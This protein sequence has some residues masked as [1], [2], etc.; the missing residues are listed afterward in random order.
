MAKI[1]IKPL[2]RMFR[3]ADALARTIRNDD[4]ASIARNRA[5]NTV[6]ESA[7]RKEIAQILRQNNKATLADVQ[8]S[9]SAKV[10]DKLPPYAPKEI[11]ILDD[12]LDRI[13]EEKLLPSA[14]INIL[15]QLKRKKPTKTDVQGVLSI[16]NDDDVIRP[17][18]QGLYL[19]G[20]GLRGEVRYFPS[21]SRYGMS[22]KTTVVRDYEIGEKNR[23]GKDKISPVKWDEM[24]VKS[25]KDADGNTVTTVESA[26]SPR[27]SLPRGKQKLV[28]IKEKNNKAKV[29]N[30]STEDSMIRS[31][32]TRNAKEYLRNVVNSMRGSSA[33][34][35]DEL[36]GSIKEFMKPARLSIPQNR[37]DKKLQQAQKVVN[38]IRGR[39]QL[40]EMYD[41]MDNVSESFQ[42]MR[43]PF[44]Q[45]FRDE[46]A[47]AQLS[48][49]FPDTPL[50]T[51]LK[52][53]KKSQPRT[54]TAIRKSMH[55]KHTNKYFVTHK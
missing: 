26:K 20:A 46:F 33:K 7:V 51:P 37:R 49:L 10:D 41:D 25:V 53:L 19:P 8:R 2:A 23:K 30:A 42:S 40:P 24:S 35:D 47:T 50:S 52:S 32:Y 48:E 13:K 27:P 6:N 44:E 21:P 31:A 3:N 5:K 55:T 11:G 12:M 15:D 17:M 16:G 29:L 43:K 39:V 54:S 9:L 28:A 38:R 22:E 34:P 36:V 4:V 45:L 14:S 1:K 18:K